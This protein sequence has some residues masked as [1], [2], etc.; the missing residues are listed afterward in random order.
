MLLKDML[1]NLR[2]FN[3]IANTVAKAALATNDPI[4]KPIRNGLHFVKQLGLLKPVVD[5]RRCRFSVSSA[6]SLQALDFL[7]R[8]LVDGD[9]NSENGSADVD[10]H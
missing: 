2:G 8:E 9:S 5:R 1:K 7:S 3:H 10:L 4:S 6:G